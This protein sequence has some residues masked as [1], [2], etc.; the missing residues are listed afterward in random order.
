MM[1]HRSRW[2]DDD[3]D[4]LSD[5][6]ARFFEKECAPH[7]ERW[8]EQQHVDR[9][10][11]NKAGEVGL[12]CLSIP[13][14]YGGGG[15]DF[16]H[17]A[18]AAIEQIRALAPSLGSPVHST[19]VAHYVANYASEEMKRAWLPK[20]ASGEAIGAIAMTEPGTG[21][22]LQGIR[23]T[24]V[25]DGDEFV[26]NGSKTFISNGYLCDFVLVVCRT[27][28]EGGGQGFSMFLVETD[29]EGFARGK[30]LKKLGQHGQ[31]T[32][33]LFYDEVRVPAANIVGEEG[34][35][36]VYLIEQLPQER[37][38]LAVASVAAMEKAVELT[39]EYTRERTAFGKPIYEFQ[40]TRFEIAECATLTEV[41]W[42][43][44][45]DCVEKQV[46]GTFDVKG[47]AMAKWWM[48]EQQTIVADRCLQLFGGYGYME[49][50]PIA[51]IFIDSRIQ[52]IYGGTNEIMK[53]VIARSL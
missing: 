45:D 51:R 47:A 13:E 11:W 9:E 44:I 34:M 22:D 39:L 30:N 14:G 21:S 43:F 40:N 46:A 7:E 15:G 31:D 20:M 29:R 5:L 36:F 41:G 53:E 17:E 33:E 16:R 12:L 32:C 50:Y 52:K 6:A 42:S 1:P 2:M 10:V 4:A 49:E 48:T 25:R 23:T 18:V 27:D 3:L 19:I 24:A 26:I 35:G 8:G 38:I 28:P 37:L